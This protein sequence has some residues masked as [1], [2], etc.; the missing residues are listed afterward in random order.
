MRKSKIVSLLMCG[1]LLFGGMFSTFTGK[2]NAPVVADTTA[3]EEKLIAD[4]ETFRDCTKNVIY[5]NLFGRFQA[6]TDS[7]YVSNGNGSI[8]LNPIGDAYMSANLPNMQI[9]LQDEDR[10]LTKLKRVTADFYNATDH[11]YEIGI[12]FKIGK[13]VES[14]TR[15]TKI[16]LKKG[17]W[18]KV[19]KTM[20][21]AVLS[22]CND[23]TDVNSVCFEFETCYDESKPN[24]IY[25]DNVRFE[26]SNTT[27]QTVEMKLDENEFCSF[28]KLYQKEVFTEN[29]YAVMSN[30][31]F[32]LSLNSD[33]QYSRNGKSLKMH[34]PICPEGMTWGWPNVGFAENLIKAV[35]FSQYDGNDEFSFWVYNTSNQNLFISLDFWRTYTTGKRSF[36]KTLYPGWN[37]ISMTFDEINAD[38]GGLDVLTDN[39]TLIR[40]CMFKFTG[41]DAVDL[42]FDDMEII[43]NE[44]E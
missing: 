7:R 11:D 37:N 1:L 32:T 26:F 19:S 43:V 38:D 9:R 5:A 29:Y 2:N 8:R 42:Y 44:N 18:T 6:N 24:D 36:T 10:D 23:M 40:I 31:G 33:L 14:D 28:D 12:F 17:E 41:V 34:A 3:Q 22:L 35:D 20:D 15:V 39:L 25:M 30:Y 27:P 13:K 4:F 21:V 16:T